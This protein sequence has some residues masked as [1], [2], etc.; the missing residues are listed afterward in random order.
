MLDTNP[1]THSLTHSLNHFSL[2][3][4]RQS[5]SVRLSR[6]GIVSERLDGSSWYLSER[7]PST[8][9]VHYSINYQPVN[10]V[11]EVRDLGVIVDS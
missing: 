5:V 1:R 9:V 10:T 8:S 4:A 3:P 2:L 6:A 7:L 11:R